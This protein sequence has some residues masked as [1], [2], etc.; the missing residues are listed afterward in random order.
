M[1]RARTTTQVAEFVVEND[2]PD[3]AVVSY[4][5]AQAVAPKPKVVQP[6]TKVAKVKGTWQMFW[7]GEVFD[8]VDGHRYE[9]PLGLFDYLKA[10]GN[11]YDT[12]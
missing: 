3:D 4:E 8:F 6:T 9:I 11:I 1:P 12:L 7:A 2:Q 10:S 5:P